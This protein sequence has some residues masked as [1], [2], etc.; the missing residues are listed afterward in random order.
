MPLHIPPA[1]PKNTTRADGSA[2]QDGDS[3]FW[4]A[5]LG[6]WVSVAGSTTANIETR[7]GGASA[8]DAT[9]ISYVSGVT[10]AIQ[11]QLD[12][13]AL[14]TPKY[15][16]A[17]TTG[18][19]SAE[20]SLGALT[21]GLLKHT[22]A[23]GVSTPATAVANSDYVTPIN[24]APS[25]LSYSGVP[26]VGTSGEAAIT[27][28]FGDVCYVGIDSKLKVIDCDALATAWGTFLCVNP[29]PIAAGGAGTGLFIQFGY[30]RNDAW[31][32]LTIGSRI[33]G[34][35]TGT[36]GNTWSETAPASTKFAQVLGFAVG[37][38]TWCFNPSMDVYQVA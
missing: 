37:A 33:W 24:P 26:V 28:S 18:D 15:I 8:P 9:E 5:A 19:L 29:T 12:A 27:I 31:G 32:A 25:D 23:A 35:V 17:E 4:D 30:I 38:K 3:V 14:K 1:I 13:K 21:T 2:H 22:V 11:T 7:L 16:V 36:S 6:R 10:S 20:V 34:T